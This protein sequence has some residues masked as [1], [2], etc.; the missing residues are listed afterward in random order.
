MSLKYLNNFKI[1]LGSFESNEKFHEDGG[2]LNGV[3]TNGEIS[4]SVG[5]GWIHNKTGADHYNNCHGFSY[6]GGGPNPYR[7]ALSAGDFESYKNDELGDIGDV[8]AEFGFNEDDNPDECEEIY[9]EILELNNQA[10]N[11][12]N[13]SDSAEYIALANTDKEIISELKE[14]INENDDENL[15]TWVEAA[16]LK[17]ISFEIE[18]G[19]E[20]EDEIDDVIYKTIERKLLA[21]GV[22]IASWSICAAGFYVNNKD[23]PNYSIGWNVTENTDSGNDGIDRHSVLCDVLSE[24]HLLD[25]ATE[26]P[27]I[28]EPAHEEESENGEY[29]VQVR[30][31]Y[32]PGMEE[33][34]TRARF[35]TEAGAKSWIDEF[36]RG[37]YDANSSNSYGPETRILHE[38]EVLCEQ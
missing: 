24:L 15:T 22:E 16:K 38:G 23:N 11:D 14:M 19:N 2:W 37:F 28:D 33:W 35:D 3:L 34:E 8:Y 5:G 20:N 26:I 13:V 27:A 18:D 25:E 6:S 4:F 1:N 7:Q 10:W 30:N 21:D 9:N 29:I 31:S 17:G 32:T 36:W 12:Y